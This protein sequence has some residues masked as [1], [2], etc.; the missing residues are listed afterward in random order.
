MLKYP[1]TYDINFVLQELRI[2]SAQRSLDRRHTI[3]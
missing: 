3:K 1:V 2:V